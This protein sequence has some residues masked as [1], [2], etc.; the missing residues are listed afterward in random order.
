M[1]VCH[2]I[3]DSL[4]F[5][6]SDTQH[7]TM[8]KLIRQEIESAI[9]E[10]ELEEMNFMLESVINDLC[11][12]T[13]N[14]SPPP[15][16]SAEPPASPQPAADSA[17]EELELEEMNFMLESLINDLCGETANPSPPPAL[18]AVPPASPQP[19]AESPPAIV[20]QFPPIT[21]PP[22]TVP[23]HLYSQPVTGSQEQNLLYHWP[24]TS[25]PIAATAPPAAPVLPAAP[26]L[27][28]APANPN[29]N[30]L[31]IPDSMLPYLR[32]V[33]VLNGVLVCDFI[34]PCPAVNTPTPKKRKRQDEQE[35]QHIK[36][37]PN[38]FMIFLKEQRAKV[39]AD[40]NI[41]GNATLNAVMGERWKSLSSDQQAKYYE[42]ADQ[43]R[44][45][46]AQKYPDWSAKVNYGKKRRGRR[47][48]TCSSV[49][50]SEPGAIRPL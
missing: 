47:S 46:H 20:Q 5:F 29:N 28:A 26:S 18:P 32:P 44:R 30:I 12:E 15:V 11:N 7:I 17:I 2:R 1:N 49:S 38:A 19:A 21:A 41:S 31:Q 35:E 22:T 48:S 6:C 8:M 3:S 16:L 37:P 34:P 36:K 50:A 14:P 23:A 9:E 13:T 25:I 27:P 43:E 40:M 45:L 4:S 42:Q 24:V 39:K 33:S 10:L